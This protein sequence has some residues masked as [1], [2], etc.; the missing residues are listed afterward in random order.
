MVIVM[1]KKCR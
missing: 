1:H